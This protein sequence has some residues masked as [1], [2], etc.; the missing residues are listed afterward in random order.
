M[1]VRPATWKTGS[2]DKSQKP[3]IDTYFKVLDRC[4]LCDIILSRV[5][6]ILAQ[7]NTPQ[8]P[9]GLGLPLGMNGWR[10]NDLHKNKVNL[11]LEASHQ[12]DEVARCQ[13]ASCNI[14]SL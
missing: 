10:H 4:R 9:E 14:L 11:F 7:K 2:K 13:Q 12:A 5:T 6:Y 3:P 1:P 8:L